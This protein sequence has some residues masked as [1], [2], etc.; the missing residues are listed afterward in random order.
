MPYQPINGLTPEQVV[1]ALVDPLLG[2]AVEAGSVRLQA[3]AQSAVSLYDGSLT[4][5]GIGAGLLLTSGKVPG[6]SNT[7]G[8]FGQDNSFSSG[9]QNGDADIDAVI[10]KVFQTKSYDATSLSFDFRVTDPA[11]T[12]ISFDLVFGS[13]EYP[14]WVNAFVDGAIVIIN[15][16]NYALFEQN[17]SRPLSVI[18]PNLA[19]GYFQNNAGNALPV[20]YDGVSRVLRI[21]APIIGGG[22]LNTIK[23]AVA[24]TGD[25]IYD[26]GLYISGLRAGNT[27]GQG[28]VTRPPIVCT[29]GSDYV[30][31][32]T[33]GESIDL[34]GGDDNCYAAGGSDI[35]DGGSGNDSIDGG[36]G[37]D[38]LKGG[39]GDDIL[40][41]GTGVDTA[42]YDGNSSDYQIST[43]ALTGVTTVA[44]LPGSAVPAGTDALSGVE[45]L[46]F[47]D[48][49]ID[50]GGGTP[51]PALPPPP[52]PVVDTPGVLVL[53]G[54]GAAGQTLT[55]ELSDVDGIADPV[56]WS[57]FQQA[58]GG[59]AWQLIDGANASTFTLTGSQAGGA[60]K[61]Q[62][63]YTDGKGNTS[64]PSSAAKSIQELE[65][66]DAVIDLMTLDAPGGA[67]VITP[68]T[69]VLQRMI[70]LGLTPAEA[71]QTLATVLG[72]SSSLKLHTYNALQLLQ[73]PATAY[74]PVAIKVE[75]VGLQLAVIASVNNDD[76]GGKLALGLL[77]AAQQGKVLDFAQAADVAAVLGLAMPELGIPAIV[78]NILYTTGSLAGK[79]DFK[80]VPDKLDLLPALQSDWVDFLNLH[81]GVTAPSFTELTIDLN[82]APIGFATAKLPSAVLDQPYLITLAQLLQGFS[83]DD[84]D[85]L[86]ISGMTA[87][88]GG[89]LQQQLD[90]N[91]LFLPDPGFTGPVELAY[92][93]SDGQGAS[94]SG[95]QMFVVK[96]PNALGTGAVLI[97]GGS[98]PLVPVAATQGTPLQLS[99]TLHDANGLGVLS[100]SWS[101][102]GV[103]ISGA[104]GFSFTPGQAEVGRVIRGHLSYTDGLGYE[105]SFD[106]LPT[107]VVANVND[108]ATGT[109]SI[110]G[111]AQQG[112][113]L[114]AS[115]VLA[116]PDGLGSVSYRWFADGVLI[117][118]AGNG[119]NGGNGGGGGGG[120]NGATLV[121]GQAQV[122]RVIT[123]E[124]SFTDGFGQL[125]TLF[126][127][128]S[129][130]VANVNDL[131]VGTVS[132]V[133]PASVGVPLQA[134]ANLQDPDGL[135]AFSYEWLADGTVM[136]GASAATLMLTADLLGRSIAARVTYTDGYG[137]V[138]SVTSAGTAPVGQPV[139]VNATGTAGDDRLL[140]NALADQLRGLAGNDTLVGYAGAD[141]LVGG[142][143]LDRLEGGEGSDLYVIELAR[144]HDAAE[145]LDLGSSGI[146]E[147][148][149]TET[150][151]STLTLFAGD[152]GL[153]RAVIGTGTGATA[154]SSS[155][156]SINIDAALA[157]NGL[158][159]VGNAGVNR[160][161][162]TA[163]NDTI[164][165]GAGGDD[166][167]G[168]RGDDV[169]IVDNARDAITELADQG[170]DRVETALTHALAANVEDL[171]LTGTAAINGTG[172]AL[173]N[174]ITGN[175]ARNVIDGGGGTDVMDGAAGS[176]LYIIA[177]ATDHSAAEIVDTGT[178]LTEVDELRFTATS[179]TLTVHAGDVGL[180]Q[181]VIGTGVAAAAVTTAKTAVHVNASAAVK[182]LILG[183]NDGDN[184]IV[185][186]AFDDRFQARLGND[187]ITGGGG[188]DSILFDT[189]LNGTSNVDRLIASCSRVRSSPAAAPLAPLSRPRSS[190]PVLVSPLVEMP[191]IASFST[192]RQASCSMTVMAAARKHQCCLPCC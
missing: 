111:T 187:S 61:A 16:V 162:G 155:I 82:V 119:G 70:E 171:R 124:A 153:E 121:L 140:G 127:A 11:A 69:T 27:P 60:V 174:R 125:E 73:A 130:I 110:S 149:F 99:H 128:P 32:D 113:L 134:A 152:V 84:L 8:W 77:A 107:A 2:V 10:N 29:D 98:D 7:V 15:G 25:H 91:W 54:I 146:D 65:T 85:P 139:V 123:A 67:G 80:P 168:G 137:Q 42:V 177:A 183:G 44:A 30:T 190:E 178:G 157:P 76:T 176:D 141:L 51:G 3:S 12:S 20:E 79:L 112:Q 145:V 46:Q 100:A 186:T 181:V 164:N 170:I 62:A 172:N 144:Y 118:T 189:A 88:G 92:A 166:M 89:Q 41:G 148:R 74:D 81:T 50:L 101:A 58:A 6:L 136:P 96:P 55:A 5:L 40:K 126:S 131:P 182:G 19:A 97:D 49:K 185:G 115:S 75:I 24:D 104:T 86:S 151:T 45:W 90:G 114:V 71:N 93:V 156:I 175:A 68:I 191:M 35:I 135:G 192:P 78:A 142:D 52:P 36:G 188:K 132:I 154:V 66:G 95:Q 180:E 22:A 14:E 138:E 21:V 4:A 167:L 53:T 133:G 184:S 102:D 94:V 173:A 117:P 59:G 1:A 9:F 38:Y 158:T 63:Q 31:G 13:D 34:L 120:N 160:L 17:P 179:G 43:D 28:L 57:W 105:E 56:V 150:S 159:L 116:D 108:P 165:G 83:D 33:T 72:L 122:G 26:S 64:S 23:I 129:E 18:S 103:L 37:D 169:Y 109:V 163:Y 47:A 161:V 106:S 147:I 39:S 48:G 87:S 143:G